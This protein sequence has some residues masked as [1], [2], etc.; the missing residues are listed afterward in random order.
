MQQRFFEE[1]NKFVLPIN[2]GGYINNV[3]CNKGIIHYDI[4]NRLKNN[5]LQLVAMIDEYNDS[6]R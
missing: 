3:E 6:V 5:D 2:F 1:E 4:G